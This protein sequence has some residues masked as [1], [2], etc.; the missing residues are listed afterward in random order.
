MKHWILGTLALLICLAAC[1]E[2][3]KFIRVSAACPRYF[4][5]IDGRP[6]IPVMINY[7]VPN[8]EEPEVFNEIETYFKHFS[9]NGG[10]A[11][12]IWISSPFLEIEDR[13]TGEYSQVKLNRIDSLLSLG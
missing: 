4:E 6:W 1:N 7:I 10:N 11:M 2:Q 9:E 3:Q 13:K 5:T 8:G 12:R